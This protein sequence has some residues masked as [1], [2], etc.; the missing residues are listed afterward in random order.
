MKDKKSAIVLAVVGS[1]EIANVTVVLE[2]LEGKIKS[3]YEDFEVRCCYTSDIILKIL[4]KRGIEL[5]NTAVV[6]DSLAVEGYSNVLVQPVM[7]IPGVSHTHLTDSMKAFK[8]KFDNLVL[9]DTLLS[10]P[11]KESD[12]IEVATALSKVADS[13]SLNVFTGHGTDHSA[14]ECYDHLLNT[15]KNQFDYAAEIINLNGSNNFEAVIEEVQSSN[16]RKVRLIPLMLFKGKH[17]IKDITGDEENSVKTRLIKSGIAVEVNDV[18]LLEMDDF[19]NS[20]LSKIKRKIY[21][22][23]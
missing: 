17:S 3:E 19:T 20:L 2:S 5:P 10:I 7:L 15:F 11:P 22:S 13:T 16:Y 9:G 18:A 6:L 8:D 12:Y 4:K 1:T 23:L 14:D 21:F